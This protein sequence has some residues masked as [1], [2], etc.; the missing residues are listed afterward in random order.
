MRLDLTDSERLIRDTA[1]R[2]ATEV[3]APGAAQAEREQR[4]APAVLR[5]LAELGLMG[6][7]L[8]GSLGGSEGS[9]LAYSL[10]VSEIA[11]ACASTAVTMA[12]TNMV[13]EILC[14]YGSRTQQ[15]TYLPKLCSGD[16]RAGSFALSEPEAGSDPAG[17]RTRARLVDGVWV[18]EGTK[19]WITSGDFAGVLVVWARTG[20]PGPKGLSA[21]LLEQGTPGLHV[22]RKENKMGLRASSTVALSL[23]GCKVPRSALLGACGEG[24]RIAMT[25]L[26]GGRIGIASQSIGIAGAALEAAIRYAQERQQFGKPISKHQAIR[27]MIADSKTELDAAELLTQRAARLKDEGRVFV[28]QAAIAKLYASEAAWRICDRALQIHGGYGYSSEL[29][30]ERYFRDA[31]VTRIYEGTS[32]IQRLVIARALTRS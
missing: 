20:G 21:F 13:A 8:P 12:V 24:F 14:R 17:L 26:N 7:T 32:E 25:A 19:Q 15:R 10:A 23:Q 22:G 4:L 6:V 9:S 28:Q 31:R 16:Y 3:V 11:R 27:W 5:G 18:L 29:P 1:R 30:L 2:F